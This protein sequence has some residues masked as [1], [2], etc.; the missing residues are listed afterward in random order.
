V[1][2]S[3]TQ[4]YQTH[5]R[6]ENKY[7]S[8][9]RSL[10]SRKA[11][12]CWKVDRLCVLVILITVLRWTWVWNTDRMILAGE[13]NVLGENPIPCHF[14][15]YPMWSNMDLCSN[16]LNHSITFETNKRKVICIFKT[17]FLRQRKHA[18]ALKQKH[19]V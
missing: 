3:R 15:T 18:V 19:T 5:E 11:L 12:L 2:H 17:R 13:T 9:Q 10:I 16:C 8:L 7:I 6:T 1:E 4:P 14:V